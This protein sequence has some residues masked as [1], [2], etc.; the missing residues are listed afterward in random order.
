MPNNIAKENFFQNAN[1]NFFQ[2]NNIES[3]LYRDPNLLISLKE[4]R[5]PKVRGAGVLGGG[6]GGLLGGGLGIKRSQDV[7]IAMLANLGWK[8]LNDLEI[9]WVKVASNKYITAHR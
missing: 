9:F 3:N 6:G 1:K 8:L 4:I 2:N 5:T 7:N